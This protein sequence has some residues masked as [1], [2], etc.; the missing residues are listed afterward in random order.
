MNSIKNCTYSFFK[1]LLNNLVR[2]LLINICV[3]ICACL[4]NTCK[5]T[6]LPVLNLKNDEENFLSSLTYLLISDTYL[7]IILVSPTSQRRFRDTIQKITC[8]LKWQTQLSLSWSLSLVGKT[9]LQIL[10]QMY[11]RTYFVWYW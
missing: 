8:K 9:I 10:T 5:G 11:T 3:K 1:R 4:L 2:R 6:G 7:K